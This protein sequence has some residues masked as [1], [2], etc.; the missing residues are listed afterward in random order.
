LIVKELCDALEL[1]RLKP[2]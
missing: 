2:N 1:A